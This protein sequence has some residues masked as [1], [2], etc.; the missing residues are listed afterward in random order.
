MTNLRISFKRNDGGAS[1]ASPTKGT[2]GSFS[3]FEMLTGSGGY[4]SDLAELVI[5]R[6]VN[7]DGKKEEDIRPFYEGIIVGGF[8]EEEAMNLLAKHAWQSNFISHRILPVANIPGDRFFREAWHDNDP[9]ETVDIDITKANEIK[10]DQFRVLRKPKLETLDAEYMK[11]L[12]QNDT[13]RQAEIVTEKQVLR[14][15]TAVVLPTDLTELKNFVPE[16][17]L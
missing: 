7:I 5:D 4:Y 6:L 9:T 16:I 11:A 2:K 12:E 14:D 3:A 10:K 1:V 15:V 17:L 13:T 8:S